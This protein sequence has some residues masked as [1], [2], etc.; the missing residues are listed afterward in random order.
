MPFD[1]YVKTTYGSQKHHVVATIPE[2]E[3]E[4]RYLARPVNVTLPYKQRFETPI[5]IGL[6][7]EPEEQIYNNRYF[8]EKFDYSEEK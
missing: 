3:K 4:V 5:S 6:V 8:D 2:F 7:I 1:Y